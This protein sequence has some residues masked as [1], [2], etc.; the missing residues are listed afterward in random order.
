MQGCRNHQNDSDQQ[1]R[2]GP[3]DAIFGGHVTCAP[4][5][6]RLL[7]AFRCS[8]DKALLSATPPRFAESAQAST[9]SAASQSRAS[10][11]VFKITSSRREKLISSS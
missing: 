1:R 3:L 2:I 8:A 4:L 6:S 11:R 9:E 7:A 5:E 10:S